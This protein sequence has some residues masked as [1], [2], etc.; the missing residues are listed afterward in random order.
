MLGSDGR[1]THAGGAPTL[2]RATHS[3]PLRALAPPH[4]MPTRA[5]RV[6]SRR[7]TECTNFLKLCKIK[8]YNYCPFHNIQSDF[9]AQTGDQ[10]A[11]GEWCPLSPFLFPCRSA[12]LPLLRLATTATAAAAA[13]ATA[14]ARALCGIDHRP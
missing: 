3:S 11:T 8:Y 4:G 7:R 12:A 5:P 14:A 6:T 10:T 9:I 1:A 13:A 2:T